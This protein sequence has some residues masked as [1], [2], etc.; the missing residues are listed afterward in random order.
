MEWILW[1]VIA[2]F[3][4][5]L[6][7]IAGY[8]SGRIEGEKKASENVYNAYGEPGPPGPVGATGAM[9]A[10]GADGVPGKDGKT[11]DANDLIVDPNL[12]LTLAEWK[13]SVDTRLTRVE[14][15]A[16]MSV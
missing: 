2:V 7:L 1:V 6:V 16:G 12:E 11:P 15:K 5:A 8:A 4:T 10:P 13:N 9:G 3:W 14:R